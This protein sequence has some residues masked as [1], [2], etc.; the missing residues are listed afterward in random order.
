VRIVAGTDQAVPGYSLHRELELYREAGFTPMEAIQA[1]TSV[2][3]RVMGLSS[4]VGTIEAGK[5][6]DLLIVDG[7]PLQHFED[8]R[9]VWLVVAG[10]KRYAPAPL[11][12]SVGFAAGGEQSE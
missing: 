3:A 12:R 5:R 1:A 4:E 7:N 2:P 10:G 9:R 8:L 6:A 11:W